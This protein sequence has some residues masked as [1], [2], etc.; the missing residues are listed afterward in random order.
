MLLSGKFHN[1]DIIQQKLPQKKI[2]VFTKTNHLE[3]LVIY[4]ICSFAYETALPISGKAGQDIH[5]Y[6]AMHHRYIALFYLIP[7]WVIYL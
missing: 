6:S 1:L 2:H 5:K 4:N 3:K 7:T